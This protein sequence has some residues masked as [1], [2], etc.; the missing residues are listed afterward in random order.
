MSLF[1]L[2][3]MLLRA[4]LSGFVCALTLLLFFSVEE[5]SR[6]GITSLWRMWV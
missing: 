3:A 5:A 1:L 4:S 6:N 2:L